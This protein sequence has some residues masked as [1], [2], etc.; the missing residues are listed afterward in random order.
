MG[1]V[2]TLPSPAQS[3]ERHAYPTRPITLVIPFPPGGATDVIGRLVARSLEQ[4]L[5]QPVV[6]DNRPG[7]GTVIGASYVARAKPDGYT[8]L[9]GS[10]STFTMNPA[11]NAALA[12]DPIK[13]F[14]ILGA[15]TQGSLVLVVNNQVPLHNI[16]EVVKAAKEKPD[17]YAYASFGAG[18]SAHFAAEM[19][20][21]AAGIHMLHVP[22]KGSA[23][24]LND[25]VGGMVP[26]AMDTVVGVL[27]NVR[28][29]RLRAI[30]VTSPERSPFLP[31][32]PTISESGY[33]AVKVSTITILAGPSGLP[34]EIRGKLEAAL[35]SAINEEGVQKQI[36]AQGTEPKFMSASDTSKLIAKELPLMKTVA[37]ASHI[38]GGQ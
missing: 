28:A 19:F 17:G 35:A 12:Y 15:A 16:Q 31:D 2:L 23:P 4:R 1:C 25:V 11:L 24:A 37:K 7:A 10:S 27:P 22:Y 18:T 6:V 30:A 21:Q 14:D 8:L 20:L 38:Q 29:G 5:G 3:S 36:K 9:W 32:V 33:S 26:M 34:A 13:S